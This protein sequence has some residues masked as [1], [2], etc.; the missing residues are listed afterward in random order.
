MAEPP[1]PVNGVV[2]VVRDL[3]R[4]SR[5]AFEQAICDQVKHLS[6]RDLALPI[7]RLRCVPRR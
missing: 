7:A 1:A 6:A 3:E 2:G 5:T 4:V